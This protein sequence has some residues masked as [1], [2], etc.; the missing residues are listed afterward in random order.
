MEK[1]K[2][3][4]LDALCDGEYLSILKEYGLTVTQKRVDALYIKVEK[5][6]S[7]NDLHAID[8]KI[9]NFILSELFFS[10]KN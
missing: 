4:I 3:I 10:N 7:Q 8:D 2:K 6:E 1:L 9:L 5:A